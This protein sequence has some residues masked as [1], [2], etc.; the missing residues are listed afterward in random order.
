MSECPATPEPGTAEAKAQ[1][2]KC[3]WQGSTH[4][5]LIP[6]RWNSLDC[7]IHSPLGRRAAKAEAELKQLKVTL[8]DLIRVAA[9][10][11]RGRAFADVEPYPDALARRALGALDDATLHTALGQPEEPK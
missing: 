6:E 5:V 10:V 9:H 4:P 3:V 11:S 2:C 7:P 1:G 8:P